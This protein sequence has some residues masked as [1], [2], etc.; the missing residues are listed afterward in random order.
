VW[1]S[2]VSSFLD[3]SRLFA[4]AL[5]VSGVIPLLWVL[6][7]KL[8]QWQVAYVFNVKDRVD[9]ESKSRQTLAQI[10]GGAVLLGGLFFT[11]QTLLTTQ[12]GQITERFTRAIEHLGD[13]ERLTVRLGGIYAL[14]R[15]A[16]DSAKD[17][18]QIMEVL[19]AYV[20][21]H[22][23]R[24]EEQAPQKE[25]IQN[26]PF[27]G[28]VQVPSQSSSDPPIEKPR[29]AAP[30]ALIMIP[31]VERPSRKL[32]TDIQAVLTVLAR[33]R[34]TFGQGEDQRLNL[35]QPDLRAADLRG[36]NLRGAD[37]GQ[38]DLREARLREA[39]LSGAL[40]D[41]ARLA[42]VNFAFA[43][44]RGAFLTEANCEKTELGEADLTDA[45]LYKADLREAR[46]FHTTLIRTDLR[47][48]D[49]RRAFLGSADLTNAQLW[50]ADL[51][52][53]FLGQALGLTREQVESAVTDEK[54]Q[55][56]D[57]L[58]TQMNPVGKQ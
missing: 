41:G 3:D 22:S 7:W 47:R 34:W 5:I 44:L 15:I 20:R 26:V 43:N 57:S 54:T 56:P 53:A 1:R 39:D 33:R 42:S 36:V 29:P 27:P 12:E 37:L 8:P 32:A 52:G 16:R 50:K 31:A 13:K 40:L 51:R 2:A 10:L 46:L 23:S 30:T 19:T 21:E 18:W 14:E 6:L 49:L 11:A 4:I 45:Y 25:E 35:S 38:A 28:Q 24:E 9:L 58:K 17:H 48:A 55:L